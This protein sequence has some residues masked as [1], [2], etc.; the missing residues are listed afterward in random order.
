MWGTY[1]SF[2]NPREHLAQ[3]SRIYFNYMSIWEYQDSF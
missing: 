1:E 2:S 3:L